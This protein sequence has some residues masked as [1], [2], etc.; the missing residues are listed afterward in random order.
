MSHPLNRYRYLF[1]PEDLP[2]ELLEGVDLKEILNNMTIE[3]VPVLQALLMR[4]PPTVNNL[5]TCR[6]V[7]TGKKPD[8]KEMALGA[9]LAFLG[10]AM[11]YYLKAMSKQFHLRNSTF[12]RFTGS[13]VSEASFIASENMDD[14]LSGKVKEILMPDYAQLAGYYIRTPVRIWDPKGTRIYQIPKFEKRA[15]L[16]DFHI[17]GAVSV[18]VFRKHLKIGYECYVLFRGTSNEFNGIPQY[19]RRMRATQLYNIPRYDPITKQN[20]PE[21]SETIPLFFPLYGEMVNDVFPH[22]I[23]CLKWLQADHSNCKRIVAAGHS[24]GGALVLLFCYTLKL[25]EET[26]WNKTFFRG[27]ATPMCA[28]QPAIQQIEQWLIDSKTRDK[29]M[30]VVNTDDFVN[31]QYQLGGRAGIE[32]ALHKGTWSF[33]S[34]IVEHY[35]ANLK[36]SNVSSKDKVEQL[37]EIVL[38][39]PEIAAASFL[40]GALESQIETVSENKRAPVRLGNRFHE[41]KHWQSNKLIDLFHGTLK[42][43]FCRRNIDWNAE[44]LGR[45]HGHYVD[46]NMNMLWPGLRTSED[47]FYRE[48]AEH[49]LNVNNNLVIIPMFPRR[50]LPRAHELL[51]TYEAY[52]DMSVKTHDA[53]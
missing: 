48:Y 36:A 44:Y 39:H 46:I 16:V 30:E 33:V 29:Y 38:T 26:L 21:G 2:T 9:K 32:K 24:Q 49:G 15:E 34:W 12:S 4:S 47:K 42:L 13:Y 28:N 43:I 40:H 23:Q 7:I 22:I 19:G 52:H 3:P 41:V 8:E 51:K 14:I 10:Y 20:H 18:F 50:D 35:L 37:I 1:N 6:D 53:I 31:I 17:V 27:Y 45:S 11:P 5:Q 25:A